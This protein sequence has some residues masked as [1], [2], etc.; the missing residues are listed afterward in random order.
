MTFGTLL[1]LAVLALSCSPKKET[2]R[3]QKSKFDSTFYPEQ[4]KDIEESLGVFGQFENAKFKLDY[5]HNEGY[6]TGN[7]YWY[8]IIVIDSLLVLYFDSPQN[9]DWNNVHYHKSLILMQNEVKMIQNE[10]KLADLGQKS[11][12]FPEWRDWSGSGYGENRLIIESDSLNIAGG[13][14]YN[15]I[16]SDDEDDFEASIVQDMN[17]SSSISGDYL[18]LFEELEKLFDSLPFLLE[19]K[20]QT[21]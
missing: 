15:N 21:F 19:D 3:I 2:T 16:F 18:S 4:K 10:V 13:M 6:S 8:E 12:G 20:N 5:Y 7:R 1:F 11:E 14:I 9:D 17:A